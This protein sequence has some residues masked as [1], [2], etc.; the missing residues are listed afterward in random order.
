M[1]SEETPEG[2]AVR[3]T[4][5]DGQRLAELRAGVREMVARQVAY[6]RAQPQGRSLTEA[7]A[8]QCPV[9]P[10]LPVRLA[11]P[12]GLGPGIGTGGAGVEGVHIPPARLEVRDT[13]DGASVVYLPEEGTE[14]EAVRDAVR[15]FVV[16]VRAG[17]CPLPGGARG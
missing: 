16:Q 3:F 17:E 15:R 7:P 8:H 2:A 11:P 10:G 14:R 6:T 13:A 5:R 4:L 9:C 12:R 1:S